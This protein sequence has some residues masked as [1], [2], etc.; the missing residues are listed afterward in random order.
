MARRSQT[1]ELHV[2]DTIKCNFDTD[3]W[4][5]GKVVSVDSGSGPLFF[6]QGGAD[7]HLGHDGDRRGLGHWWLYD[8]D[9]GRTWRKSRSLNGGKNG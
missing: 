3:Q 1:S 7:A 4:Y 9:E 5:T 8:S 6:S 2:G